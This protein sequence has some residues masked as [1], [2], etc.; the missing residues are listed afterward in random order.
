MLALPAPV[1]LQEGM[2]WLELLPLLQEQIHEVISAGPKMITTTP[3]QGT[4]LRH[5]PLQS[6]GVPIHLRLTELEVLQTEKIT[7]L[8]PV[9]SG[10]RAHR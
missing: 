2:L 7:P 1:H 5:Q 6:G 4:L 3:T 9:Q 10:H 8:L